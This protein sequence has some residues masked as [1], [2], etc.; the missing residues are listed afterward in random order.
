MDAIEPFDYSEL[1]PF[2]TAYMPGFLAER[3]DVDV[4]ECEKRARLRA[5]N[6]TEQIVAGTVQGYSTAT[7]AGRNVVMRRSAVK[8]MMLP[9][10]FM[11][12]KYND[13]MYEFAI[14]GQTGKLAGT[15]PLDKSRLKRFSAVIGAAVA[16]AALLFSGGIFG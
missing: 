8:Y 16:L 15:P 13:K 5:A 7:P 9:V 14:N 12:Y 11:T 6:T 1:K 3:Y 2:S 4:E 10:W